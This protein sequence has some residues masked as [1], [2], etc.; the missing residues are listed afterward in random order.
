M[1]GYMDILPYPSAHTIFCR[2]NFRALSHFHLVLGGGGVPG[3]V[4]NSSGIKEIGKIYSVY[5]VIQEIKRLPG[6]I[7]SVLP[8]N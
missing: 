7:Y 5:S 3:M 4:K 2:A 1:V 8:R 6:K